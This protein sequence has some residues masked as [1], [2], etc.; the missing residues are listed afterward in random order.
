MDDNLEKLCRF[1]LDD[2][3]T[4]LT[5]LYKRFPG[6]WFVASFGLRSTICLDT[7]LQWLF[8]IVFGA[9]FEQII[10]KS[11]LLYFKDYL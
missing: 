10:E 9:F 5:T 11:L 6:N 1:L 4:M 2:D 7:L 3:S 8:T